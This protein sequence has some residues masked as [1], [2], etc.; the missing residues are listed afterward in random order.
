MGD[1]KIERG[2]CASM[3]AYN[4]EIQIPQSSNVRKASHFMVYIRT[5]NCTYICIFNLFA[6][7]AI[8]IHIYSIYIHMYYIT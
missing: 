3:T 4:L 7:S 8:Y 5:Y 2:G 1:R 6:Y